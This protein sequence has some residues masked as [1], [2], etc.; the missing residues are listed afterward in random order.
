M[1][2]RRTIGNTWKDGGRIAD[3]GSA[4]SVLG[5]RPSC[6]WA[7]GQGDRSRCWNLPWKGVGWNISSI[8][9]GWSGGVSTRRSGSTPPIVCKGWN[10][11]VSRRPACFVAS[12]IELPWLSAR[13]LRRPDSDP[14]RTRGRQAPVRCRLTVPAFNGS[15]VSNASSRHL[16]AVEATKIPNGCHGRSPVGSMLAPCRRDGAWRWLPAFGTGERTD[17]PTARAVRTWSPRP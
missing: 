15:R 7:A 13:H 12:A 16:R 17:G 9:L 5:T 14:A 11:S 10:I 3:S 8:S 6:S 1:W 2:V 4:I